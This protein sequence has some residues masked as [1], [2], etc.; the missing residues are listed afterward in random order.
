MKADGEGT[1][2]FIEL[3]FSAAILI[4]DKDILVSHSCLFV[5][6]GKIQSIIWRRNFQLEVK[7]DDFKTLLTKE[8]FNGGYYFH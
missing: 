8:I 1:P 5:A 4:D 7:F 6:R 3:L 2:Y